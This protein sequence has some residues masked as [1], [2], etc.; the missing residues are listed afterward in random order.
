[1]RLHAVELRRIQ[2]SLVAPFETS[3]GVQ[4]ERDIL[5]LKAVTDAGEGWGECV[6]GED[7]HYSP[8]YVDGAQHVLVHH[9]L[10]RLFDREPGPKRRDVV[11][12]DRQRSSLEIP[13]DEI[14]IPE[15]L[16]D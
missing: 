2:M 12:D 14:D 11:M 15:F 3:F 7:P 6:A 9:M 5:L 4:T 16:K 13:D 8:E 10:P 1:M